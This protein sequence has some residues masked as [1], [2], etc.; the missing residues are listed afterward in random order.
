[1]SATSEAKRSALS[2]QRSRPFQWMVRAGFVAR[3]LTYGVVGGITLALALGAGSAP[4]APD[5]QG[6]L[7]FIAH[8]P[9]GRV[10]VAVA[11]AGLLGY[12]LWKL[13]QAAFG[14]GPEGGGDPDF[15]DRV[16][17]AAGGV[18]Y[19]VFFAVALRVLFSGHGS[20]GGSTT[21]S[22]ATAGVLGWP[23]GPVIVGIAGAVLIAI[24]AVQVYLAWRGQFAEDAKLEEMSPLQR[25]TYM[26]LGRVGLIARAL[27]FALIGYFVLK[28][29]IDFNS[30]DAVGLDGVL[31]R[32]HREPFGPWLLGLVAAGLL[33]F[34]AYSVFDSRYRR[35]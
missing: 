5:Q 8:A 12:A 35:L 23:G 16:S 19:L 20:G 27:V 17:N 33:V 30:R 6:A 3:G 21:P 13:G 1:M 26:L 9:F 10:A 2:A 29:A 28:A 7:A 11:A 34:A 32:V 15:K 22:K 4:A 24:S 14:R 25:R 18:A 31:A